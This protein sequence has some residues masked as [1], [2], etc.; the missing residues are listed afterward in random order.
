MLRGTAISIPNVRRTQISVK[1][2]SGRYAMNGSAPEPTV[3]FLQRTPTT[4][5]MNGALRAN[6]VMLLRVQYIQCSVHQHYRI[7][8]AR[9]RVGSMKLCSV[10]RMYTLQPTETPR[11]VDLVRV[12]AM[13][14]RTKLYTTL[15]KFYTGNAGHGLIVTH[16][17]TPAPRPRCRKDVRIQ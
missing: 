17:R 6:H 10:S 5:L 9:P 15:C 7:D 11:L 13:R 8:N 12:A 4:R 14:Q 16:N 1:T 2:L 3:R